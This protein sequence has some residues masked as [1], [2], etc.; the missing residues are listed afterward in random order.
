MRGKE[1][2]LNKEKEKRRR[3]GRRKRTKIERDED[4]S[5]EEK[6][7]NSV[8]QPRSS[9]GKNAKFLHIF[10]TSSFNPTLAKIQ[11]M[12]L[13]K[14]FEWFFQ[15]IYSFLIN[16]RFYDKIESQ[17]SSLISFNFILQNKIKKDFDKR[18]KQYQT[19]QYQILLLFLL[20]YKTKLIKKE[21]MTPSFSKNLH[22]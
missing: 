20:L 14:I 3:R 7:W 16:I 12:I 13:Q 21:K 6:I 18:F 10:G 17:G 9:R 4:N 1:E 15:S 19:F 5:R 2:K 11:K 8:S 22:D